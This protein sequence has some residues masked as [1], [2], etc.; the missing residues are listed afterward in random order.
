[1]VCSSRHSLVL[2]VGVPSGSTAK[3]IKANVVADPA[4]PCARPARFAQVDLE[5]VVAHASQFDPD[6]A[7]RS[8]L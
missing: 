4:S 5:R 2:Q 6:P 7:A 3:A 8:D 1:M